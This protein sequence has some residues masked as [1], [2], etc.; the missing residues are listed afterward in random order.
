[1]LHRNRLVAESAGR[2]DKYF[3]EFFGIETTLKFFRDRSTYSLESNARTAL[4]FFVQIDIYVINNLRCRDD[5]AKEPYVN[6]KSHEEGYG[7]LTD[8]N[9]FEMP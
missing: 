1:M 8:E 9:S 7:F 6:I 5:T 4:R 3:P 2:M